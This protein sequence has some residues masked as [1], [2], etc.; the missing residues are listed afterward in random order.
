MPAIAR[1]RS[2]DCPRSL[3]WLMIEWG[4]RDAQRLLYALT[5]DSTGL[6]E[7]APLARAVVE[8]ESVALKPSAR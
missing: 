6:F 4:G 2:Q 3:D 5:V 1:R 7:S 8:E